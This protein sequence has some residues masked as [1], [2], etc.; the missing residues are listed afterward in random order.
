MHLC[1]EH[2]VEFMCQLNFAEILTV[3]PWG[4][5]RVTDTYSGLRDEMGM[6]A[7]AVSEV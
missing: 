5:L 3:H 1:F 2:K 4:N 7:M 6:I